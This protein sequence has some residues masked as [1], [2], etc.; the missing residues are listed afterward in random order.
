MFGMFDRIVSDP[1]LLAGK[2]HVRGTRIS[3]EVVLEW[4]ASGGT[5]AEIVQAYPHLAPADVEQAVRY[6]AR[7]LE[8]EVVVTAEVGA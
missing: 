4:L 2:P 8:N 1:A 6:A 7:F 5:M 3:V